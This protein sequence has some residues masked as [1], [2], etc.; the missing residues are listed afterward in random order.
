[1]ALC[2]TFL[3]GASCFEWDFLDEKSPVRLLP[4]HKVGPYRV[5]FLLRV[6]EGGRTRGL[7][8]ECDGHDFHERTKEQAA[9]DRERDRW[10]QAHEYI[11]FRFTG[12]QI[13]NDPMRCAG[14]VEQWVQ[15]ALIQLAHE[16]EQVA[17]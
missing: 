14:E 8:I 6:E 17:P 9:A 7:V 16:A 3:H 10:L 11:V 12:S 13:W 1:M 2:A 5:D 15:D 4:Q